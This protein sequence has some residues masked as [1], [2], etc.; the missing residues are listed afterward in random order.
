MLNG[1]SSLRG[2]HQSLSKRLTDTISSK[3][4]ELAVGLVKSEFE[5][6]II[7]NREEVTI[8]KSMLK[9][10]KFEIENDIMKR[11]KH[12]QHEHDSKLEDFYKFKSDV[13]LYLDRKVESLQG[14]YGI[15]LKNIGEFIETAEDKIR[16]MWD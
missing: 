1:Y 12:Q 7:K 8:M 14:N 4:L 6:I 16:V 9:T 15:K 11:I 2:D 10:L 5:E 13:Y 3:E